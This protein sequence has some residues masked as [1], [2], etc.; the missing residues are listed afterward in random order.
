MRDADPLSR[1]HLIALLF[2]LYA[3]LTSPVQTNDAQPLSGSFVF[4]PAADYAR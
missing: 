1:E 2:D 4:V 3:A